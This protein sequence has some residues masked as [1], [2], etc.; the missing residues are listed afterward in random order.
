LPW[1]S[2]GYKER[3]LAGDL[4]D[5]LSNLPPALQDDWR[6]DHLYARDPMIGHVTGSMAPRVFGVD[7][8][9]SSGADV[10]IVGYYR[11]LSQ[12]GARSTYVMALRC[13]VRNAPGYFMLAGPQQP[14]ELDR[15][16]E[17]RGDRLSLAAF[18]ADLRLQMLFH[19]QM[20]ASVK[21]TPREKECLELLSMG[22]KNER[23]ASRLGLSEVTVRLHFTNAR[24]KLHTS[25]REQAVARAAM[26]GLI[27]PDA[28]E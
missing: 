25:T 9:Q 18:Y 13:I 21:L 7:E 26:L 16:L 20:L 28:T 23:I 2:Y 24:K 8:V 14:R 17:E 10:A 1:I 5:A 12:A 11:R 19:Q 3:P 6:R 15:L 4:L 27:S 22:F